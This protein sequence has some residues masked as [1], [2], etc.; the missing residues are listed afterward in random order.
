MGAWDAFRPRKW[1]D[2]RPIPSTLYYMR[3]YFG[4]KAAL[5]F[6]LQ[7]VPP[8]LLPYRFK[9]NRKILALGIPLVLL[10]LPFV[11]IQVIRSWRKAS[12]MIKAG[13]RIDQL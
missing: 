1:T 10:L 4:R 6:I 3:R 5:Y 9:R 13:P 12:R 2:P 7:G 8:S 11:L